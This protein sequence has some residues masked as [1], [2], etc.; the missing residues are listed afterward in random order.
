MIAMWMLYSVAV[1]LLVGCA[2]WLLE[3]ALIMRRVATRAI[4][5]TSLAGSLLLVVAVYVRPQPRIENGA[6]TFVGAPVTGESAPPVIETG[7][8]DQLRSAAYS[9]DRPLAALWLISILGILGYICVSQMTLARRRKQWRTASV[10]GVTLYVSPDVGPALVGLRVPTIVVPEWLL[11]CEA[12]QQR[13]VV[14]HEQAH[15]RA[16][17]PLLLACGL[18]LALLMPWNLAIWWQLRRLRFAI[19]VDCDARVMKRYHDVRGYGDL[20]LTV[21]ARVAHIDAV[22]MPATF[23]EPRSLLERRIQILAMKL[24]RFARTR[25]AVL[26]ALALALIIAACFSPSP[27]KPSPTA[28]AAEVATAHSG[29]GPEFTP[30]TEPPRLLN[31]VEIGKVLESEYPPLLRNAGVEGSAKVWVHVDAAGD[32]TDARI[33][34][35]SGHVPLDSAALRTAR[36]M[37]FSGAKN[38]D[39]P[40]AVW[41]VLPIVFK[42]H[43]SAEAVE[44]RSDPRNTDA[45]SKGPEFT[46]YTVAPE[47]L[48]RAAVM[49]ALEEFYPPL[50]RNAGIEGKTLVWLHLNSDGTVTDTRVMKSSGQ[51]ALDEAA[52]RTARRMKFSGARNGNQPAAVWIA[53]PIVFRLHP[54]AGAQMGTPAPSALSERQQ[55]ESRAAAARSAAVARRIAVQLYPELASPTT[56]GRR[57][58]FLVLNRG[59]VEKKAMMTQYNGPLNPTDALKFAFPEEFASRGIQSADAVVLWRSAEKGNEL[60]IFCWDRSGSAPTK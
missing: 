44:P 15:A 30:Y 41:V 48:N 58:V 34:E 12:T 35:S 50:L 21:A 26:S 24:P 28:P 6:A 13:L 10:D 37:K 55:D 3:R 42:V 4:W 39:E 51:M 45:S 43:P 33:R 11:A 27:D 17:D 36:R 47:L 22:L 59:K 25:A 46:P 49:K 60:F 16:R 9:A 54:P 57:V 5:L 2:A 19:E 38:R 56:S 18:V 53:L 23:S 40:A 29:T 8:L 20:L 52:L 14:A 1:A 32:V 7:F 31:F